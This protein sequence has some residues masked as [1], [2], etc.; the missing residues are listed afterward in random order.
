MT[1]LSQEIE[2][3]DC[4]TLLSKK[5]VEKTAVLGIVGLGYVGVPLA[6]ASCMHGVKTVGFDI[7]MRKINDLKNGVSYIIVNS[8]N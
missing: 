1:L 8:N 2:T 6:V 7:E 3:Q 5:V 4:F